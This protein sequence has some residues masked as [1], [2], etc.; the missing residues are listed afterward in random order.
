MVVCAGSTVPGEGG[1]ANGG[2]REAGPLDD[3]GKGGLQS[4]YTRSRKSR[5]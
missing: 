4:V 1:A 3:S 2:E 5:D